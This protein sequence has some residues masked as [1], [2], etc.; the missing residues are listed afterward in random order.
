MNRVVSTSLALA[1]VATSLVSTPV[2]AQTFIKDL[3]R[4]VSNLFTPRV[5]GSGN[6]VQQTREFAAFH[7]VRVDAPFGVDIDCI[8]SGHPSVAIQAD[9]NLV[10]LIS[11]TLKDGV[12]TISLDNE[13]STQGFKSKNLKVTVNAPFAERIELLGAGSID[14]THIY[15]PTMGLYMSGVGNIT[16][17]GSTQDLTI[18]AHGVGSIE[19]KHFRAQNASV[20]S[21]GI[22][23]TNV[24]ASSKLDINIGGIGSLV[25]YG[26]PQI[27]NKQAGGIG[28]VSKGNARFE[29]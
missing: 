18:D 3:G 26:N 25:Y 22:G 8:E 16:A 28:S 5:V 29:P 21:H 17:S 10:P 19:A 24:Y 27:V 15:R 4:A 14:I 20:S 7:T 1:L 12:L 13:V 9:D 2:S 11:T 23:S 6:I